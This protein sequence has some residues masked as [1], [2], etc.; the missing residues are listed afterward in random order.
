MRGYFLRHIALAGHI[1]L[2]VVL[3]LGCAGV[4][5]PAPAPA[6]TTMYVRAP[7]DAAWTAA[8]QFFTDAGIS[9]NTSDKAS[10]LLAAK[11]FPMSAEQ[12]GRWADCGTLRRGGSAMKELQDWM[13]KGWAR[14]QGD[15]GVSLRPAADS[16]AV[17]V[18]VGFRAE[19]SGNPKY[20]PCVTSNVFEREMFEYIRAHAN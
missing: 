5:P 15:F 6:P 16:T 2:V 20:V 4:N 1:A 10:G 9:I 8:V 3:T 18:T 13:G 14:A 17:R 11:D 19:T 7:I 12:V